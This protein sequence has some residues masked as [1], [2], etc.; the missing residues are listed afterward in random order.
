MLASNLLNNTSANMC[1]VLKY[2]EWTRKKFLSRDSLPFLTFESLQV[3]K[4]SL[5]ERE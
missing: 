2:G 4:K 1:S 5:E 3:K